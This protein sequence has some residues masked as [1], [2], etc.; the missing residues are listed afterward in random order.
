MG[1]V[2]ES[3]ETKQGYMGIIAKYIYTYSKLAFTH[4]CLENYKIVFPFTQYSLK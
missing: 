1:I 4:F 3:V 2:R